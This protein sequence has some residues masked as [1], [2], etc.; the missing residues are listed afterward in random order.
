MSFWQTFLSTFYWFCWL[1]WDKTQ[2]SVMFWQH[3]TGRFG[4]ISGAIGALIVASLMA[5]LVGASLP[6]TFQQLTYKKEQALFLL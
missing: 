3:R 5:V 1:N 2:L 4:G 6:G